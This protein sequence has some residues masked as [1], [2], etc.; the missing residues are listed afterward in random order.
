M[1]KIYFSSETYPCCECSTPTREYHIE[2]IYSRETEERAEQQ[3]GEVYVSAY[4][5]WCDDEDTL[6]M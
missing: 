3:S 2:R 4:F 6:E 5:I 1:E